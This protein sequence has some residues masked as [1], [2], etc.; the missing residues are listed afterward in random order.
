[1]YTI[2]LGNTRRH[3][4]I[5]FEPC[6]IAVISNFYK[7]ST[8][9]RRGTRVV[10]EP[11]SLYDHPFFPQLRASSRWAAI[12]SDPE[13]RSPQRIRYHKDEG[14]PARSIIILDRSGDTYTCTRVRA[15]ER[16]FFASQGF[17]RT[18]LSY[19]LVFLARN[20]YIFFL[21]L[22]RV[23]RESSL[24][25]KS[26]KVIQDLYSSIRPAASPVA[27]P[28]WSCPSDDRFTRSLFLSLSVG[29]FFLFLFLFVSLSYNTLR[30]IMNFKALPCTNSLSMY[31]SGYLILAR[32]IFEKSETASVGCEM[33]GELVLIYDERGFICDSTRNFEIGRHRIGEFGPL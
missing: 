16:G 6:N 29:I 11:C 33:W 17:P 21:P 18:R 15:R 19:A 3:L 27:H 28:F 32:D 31:S 7:S 14:P 8:G 5:L 22:P 25:W 26:S 20:C 1:M 9:L 13:L 2:S 23:D 10:G 12:T 24:H 30:A 4:K